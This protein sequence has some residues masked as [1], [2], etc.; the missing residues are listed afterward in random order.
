MHFAFMSSLVAALALADAAKPSDRLLPEALSTLPEKG[1]D[2]P[3]G[4]ILDAP[5]S[6]PLQYSCQEDQHGDVFCVAEDYPVTGFLT[7]FRDCLPFDTTNALQ[8]GRCAIIPSDDTP[9]E[10]DLVNDKQCNSC[11]VCSDKAAYNCSNLDSGDCSVH[12][13]DGTCSS[14]VGGEVQPSFAPS[15]GAAAPPTDL[16]ARF[17]PGPGYREVS[18]S[19]FILTTKGAFAIVATTG[20]MMALGLF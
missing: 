11:T 18:S 8:C 16:R 7:V 6:L 2:S 15:T 3:K 19:A 14:G 9:L 17:R 5:K 10:I 12:D 20:S 1:N 4:I 13:C